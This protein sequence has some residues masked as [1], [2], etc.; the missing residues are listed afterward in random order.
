MSS[1]VEISKK[2]IEKGFLREVKVCWDLKSKII[3]DENIELL[4]LLVHEMTFY[5]WDLDVAKQFGNKEI[6]K[7]I[8]DSQIK[9][10]QKKIQSLE[11]EI[12]SLETEIQS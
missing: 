7:I 8:V 3:K 6:I 10:L 12:Q 4:K 1:D 2:L 11:A 5:S 9:P